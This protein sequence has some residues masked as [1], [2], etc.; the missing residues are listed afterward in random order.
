MRKKRKIKMEERREGLLGKVELK[1]RRAY[2]IRF[3]CKEMG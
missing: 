1:E 2:L 3:H